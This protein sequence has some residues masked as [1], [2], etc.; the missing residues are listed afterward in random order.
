MGSWNWSH[1]GAEGWIAHTLRSIKLAALLLASGGAMVL[2]LI[3]PFWEQPKTLQVCSVAK[4]I[5]EEMDKRAHR[6]IKM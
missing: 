4:T 1:L 2:H 6:N 3:V 5:C